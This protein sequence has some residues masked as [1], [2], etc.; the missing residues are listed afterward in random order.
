MNRF[1]PLLLAAAMAIAADV[2]ADPERTTVEYFGDGR[3]RV[4]VPARWGVTRTTSTEIYEGWIPGHW[5]TEGAAR[6]VATQTTTTTVVRHTQVWP[7]P[8]V[9]AP[10]IAAP[11]IVPIWHHQHRWSFGVGAVWHAPLRHWQHCR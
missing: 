2:P 10:V 7:G 5:V 11:V 6:P 1:L 4:W 9:V 3:V 8:V